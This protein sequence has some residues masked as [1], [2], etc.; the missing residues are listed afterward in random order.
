MDLA[1]WFS[2]A[3]SRLGLSVGVDGTTL[4]IERHGTS[5]HLCDNSLADCD[6]T[7][8]KQA[9][10]A[11]ILFGIRLGIDKLSMTDEEDKPTDSPMRFR[12]T[13]LR[14][15]HEAPSVH[16]DRLPLLLPRLTR[17]I[18]EV[19]SSQQAFARKGMLPESDVLVVNETGTKLDILSLEEQQHADE[20]EPERWRKVRSALFYQSYKVRPKEKIEL[21]GGALRVFETVEGFGASRA[22]L[23][24]EFD[25]DASREYGYLAVPTRDQIIIARP[26]ERSDAPSLLPP[27]RKAIASALQQS[28]FGL[29]DAIFQLHPND[30]TPLHEGAFHVTED[31]IDAEQL[32]DILSVP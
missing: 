31:G 24:P 21:E 11:W 8:K 20:S 23:L 12:R 1:P 30:V 29:S 14:R 26:T 9:Q 16:G 4:L 28:S 7:H 27:L 25:Y 19:V 22:L 6:T 2:E 3:A 18:F 13:P 17:K 15:Y 5:V 10:A 32:I